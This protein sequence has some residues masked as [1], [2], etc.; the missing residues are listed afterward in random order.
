MRVRLSLMNATLEPQERI[1]VLTD[2]HRRLELRLTELER[3]LSLSPDE[4]RER[5]ELKKAKLQ[6]KDQLLSLQRAR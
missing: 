1:Q 3:H 5:A 4:Q 2:E 6:V